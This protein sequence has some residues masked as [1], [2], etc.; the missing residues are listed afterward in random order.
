MPHISSIA[1]W[2]NYINLCGKG[3]IFKYQEALIGTQQIEINSI[4]IKSKEGF[5]GEG[6]LGHIGGRQVLS[7]LLSK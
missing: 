4:Q 1:A 7:P 2:E 5:W 3:T 6:K